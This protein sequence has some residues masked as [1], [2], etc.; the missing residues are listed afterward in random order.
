[1]FSYIVEMS[2]KKKS[3]ELLSENVIYD[4]FCV[5]GAQTE[6]LIVYL[7]AGCP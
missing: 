5:S 6:K 3:L 1:M 2:L 4:Y 7:V